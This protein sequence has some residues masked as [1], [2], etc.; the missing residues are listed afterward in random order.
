MPGIRRHGVAM[1]V[2]AVGITVTACRGGGS[3]SGA[4][5]AGGAQSAAPA[6]TPSGASTA[7]PSDAG[8]SA[9]VASLD[10]CTTITMDAV[11]AAVG[12]TDP[13]GTI[14]NTDD[15][16]DC[17]YTFST[18]SA[19]GPVGWQVDLQVWDSTAWTYQLGIPSDNRNDVA[20]LGDAA[21][22]QSDAGTQELWVR[23]GS[24]V[25]SVVAPDH[26]GAADLVRKIAKLALG[27]Y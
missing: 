2:L 7:A 8:A 9:A 24:N 26:D 12:G 14:T 22:A 21:F 19:S 5:P 17:A 16:S 11:L 23:H 15:K 18:P 6:A 1:V 4:T 13:Q 10:V 25:I 3:G 20:G 27:S